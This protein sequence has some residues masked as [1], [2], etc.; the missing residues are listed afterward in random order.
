VIVASSTRGPTL[1]FPDK[2]NGSNGIGL[3]P[4]KTFVR[5]VST[6]NLVFKV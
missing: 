1:K 5:L 2:G 6:A 4:L 3:A